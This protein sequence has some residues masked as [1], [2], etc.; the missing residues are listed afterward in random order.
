M[1]P[2]AL[3]PCRHDPPPGWDAQTFEA[4]ANAIATALVAAVRRKDP[5]EEGPA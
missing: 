5:C 2:A 3:K 1:N 4:V